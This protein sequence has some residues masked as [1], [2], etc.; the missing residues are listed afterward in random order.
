[1]TIPQLDGCDDFNLIDRGN[2]EKR[3]Y[4]VKCEIKEIIQLINF[5][6]SFN[7]LWI[8]T[9]SH[10]LCT[11]N[12][13]CFFCYMR[14][15]CLRLR[16]TRGRGPKSLKLI[17]FTSQLNQYQSLL[18]WNWRESA[19]DMVKFIENTMRL[20]HKREPISSYLCLANDDCQ[21]CKEDISDCVLKVDIEKNDEEHFV[22][23]Q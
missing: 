5:L 2:M 21:L 11:I 22:S 10:W 12:Q 14:S 8:S 13:A 18:G 9:D 4:G 16:A 7:F 1:M 17:E 15:S 23:L 6:R 20:I 3:I 19:T